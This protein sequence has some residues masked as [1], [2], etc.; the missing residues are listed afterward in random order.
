MQKN[1]RLFCYSVNDIYSTMNFFKYQNLSV[2]IGLNHVK[3]RIIAQ[4]LLL[5]CILMSGEWCLL[6]F[7]TSI[8]TKSLTRIP[9]IYIDRCP[10]GVRMC[11]IHRANLMK[12]ECIKST[13]MH[14]RCNGI[15]QIKE[16]NF[17]D[18]YLP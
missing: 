3:F 6:V 11:Q 10:L 13:L 16:D 7:R 18:S 14:Q 4:F 2:I 15:T 8:V 9:I 17:H 1:T 5:E 12:F